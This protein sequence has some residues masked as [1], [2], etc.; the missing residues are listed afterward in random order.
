MSGGE[1]LQE[2]ANRKA[3]KEEL[4]MP[5]DE[6]NELADIVGQISSDEH[7]ELELKGFTRNEVLEAAKFSLKGKSLGVETRNLNV[8]D[9]PIYY[10]QQK[11]KSRWFT[12]RKKLDDAAKLLIEKA[13]ERRAIRIAEELRRAEEEERR[14]LEAERERVQNIEHTIENFSLDSI[15]DVPQQ[16]E[17]KEDKE[18][19]ASIEKFKSSEVFES[20]N[21]GEPEYSE[22]IDR[23]FTGKE[24]QDRMDDR[25][26]AVD[27]N[28]ELMLESIN[29]VLDKEI[30][31]AEILIQKIRDSYKNRLDAEIRKEGKTQ[32]DMEADKARFTAAAEEKIASIRKAYA[33]YAAGKISPEAFKLFMHPTLM[34]VN[35]EGES[36]LY[37]KLVGHRRNHVFVA[38]KTADKRYRTTLN[39][40]SDALGYNHEDVRFQTGR[41]MLSVA[42]LSRNY[43]GRE[44]TVRTSYIMGK[45]LFLHFHGSKF[46]EKGAQ[47]R[48]YITCKPDKQTE[49]LEIW[50]QTLLH[51][52]DLKDYLH[53][54]VR[55]NY[56]GDR[57]ESLVLYTSKSG[58]DSDR[59]D[60]FIAEFR[61]AAEQAGILETKEHMLKTTTYMSDGISASPEFHPENITN[62]FGN[63]GI[64]D[65][66]FHKKVC[67]GINRH[68]APQEDDPDP[69]P[70]SARFSYNTFLVRAQYFATAIVRRKKNISDNEPLP[71]DQETEK[72]VKRYFADFIRMSGVDPATMS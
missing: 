2:Y 27:R 36:V 62:V 39:N 17:W 48:L 70:P 54:K 71:K 61:Q 72:M 58:V 28:K 43:P 69:A 33:D 10:N 4:K 1:T 25:P 26:P 65:K 6:Y 47:R 66:A 13:K 23:I 57:R 59:L 46:E 18:Y 49:M 50:Q 52:G 34:S 37:S 5:Q 60:A 44:K 20:M 8:S 30:P 15:E 40:M 38:D 16:F 55:T 7:E 56:S 64:Y 22:D 24:I 32:K 51:H 9:S 21:Q 29:T 31:S 68:R 11:K 42:T 19:T 14:R 41:G 67:Y 12:S 63:E 45:N 3:K 53:F 35:T